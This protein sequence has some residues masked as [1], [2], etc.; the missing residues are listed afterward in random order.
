MPNPFPK[1]AATDWYSTF[2]KFRIGRERFWQPKIYA[3]LTQ[4]IKDATNF[5]SVEQAIIS[6]MFVTAPGLSELLQQIHVDSGRVMGAKAYQLVMKQVKKI[7]SKAESKS[8]LPIG[9]NEEL[10]NEIIEFFR[11][12]NLALVTEITDTM[13]AW[14]LEKLIEGQ[15]QAKSITQIA[16]EMIKDKF[17]KNRAIV[18]ARTEVIKAAN[19]GA[20]RGAK[21]TGYKMNKQ[22]VASQDNRTRRVPRDGYSHLAMD[23][24]NIPI[25]EKFQVPKKTGGY[26]DID[27]PGAPNGDAGNVIQCR[28]AV[29]FVVQ[30]GADGLPVKA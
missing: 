9:A 20:V 5:V 12:H 3:I 4:L 28:C 7:K 16:D 25:D 15:Q 10:V 27:Q 1:S 26:D 13:K 23:G 8:L 14:I 19:Y 29:G 11:A 22:W 30:T 17:P 6:H 2:R 24:I 18:V 21:K